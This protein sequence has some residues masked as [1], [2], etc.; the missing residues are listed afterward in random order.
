MKGTVTEAREGRT[1]INASEQRD[2]WSLT[3][4]IIKMM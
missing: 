4:F 1:K 2:H 3:T